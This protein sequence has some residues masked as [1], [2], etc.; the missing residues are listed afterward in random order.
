MTLG[1]CTSGETTDLCADIATASTSGFY[2]SAS[3]NTQVRVITSQNAN[4]LCTGDLGIKVRYEND[5]I[6]RDQAPQNIKVEFAVEDGSGEPPT[7]FDPG[8]PE[9]T[10]LYGRRYKQWSVQVNASDRQDPVKYYIRIGTD[11]LGDR[12]V[13]AD[14][15]IRY[16]RYHAPKGLLH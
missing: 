5:S 9:Y 16:T 11:A 14:A 12:P 7:I 10:T 1:G 4:K 8:E 3:P 2:Y 13:L 6:S 15:V